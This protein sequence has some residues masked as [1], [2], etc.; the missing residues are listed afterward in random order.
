MKYVAL[1][2]CL[3]LSGCWTNQKGE[4]SGLLVKVSKEGLFWGTYEAELIRGGFNN[5]SGAN[6]ASFH[7]TVGKTENKLVKTVLSLLDSNKQVIISYHC[8]FFVAPWRG[9]TKCLL[10]NIREHI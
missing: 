1:I 2:L 4:K 10:D 7:F 8:E 5:A 6:G 3:L 9:G